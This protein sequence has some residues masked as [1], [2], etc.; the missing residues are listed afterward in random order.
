M[1]GKT[2]YSWNST[3]TIFPN[4]YPH[5]T[6]YSLTKLVIGEVN[7]PYDRDISEIRL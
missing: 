3:R 5:S 6:V 2:K 1:E 7:L 4:K